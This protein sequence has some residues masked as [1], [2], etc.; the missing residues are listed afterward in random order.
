MVGARTLTFVI[1]DSA[2]RDVYD[3]RK[4]SGWMSLGNGGFGEESGEW[5]SYVIYQE[6][7]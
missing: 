6:G 7:W 1:V 5:V 4:S 2:I 3:S